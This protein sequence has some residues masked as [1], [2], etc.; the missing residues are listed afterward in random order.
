VRTRAFQLAILLL[1]L[2]VGAV[3]I[4]AGNYIRFGPEILFSPNAFWVQ[5]TGATV[6]ALLVPP[7]VYYLAELYDTRADFT[8]VRWLVRLAG[9]IVAAFLFLIALFYWFPSWK[10]WRAVLFYEALVYVPALV[11]VRVLVSALRNRRRP[12]NRALVVGLGSRAGKV[13]EFLRERPETG[14]QVLGC[15]S[16]GA[17]EGDSG[18]AA[19]E[20]VGTCADLTSLIQQRGVRLVIHTGFEPSDPC[21]APVLEAKLHGATVLE[22]IEMF[23]QIEQRIPVDHIDD[24]WLLV[25]NG[26][27]VLRR[28]MWQRV[29]RLVDIFG[30]ALLLL[31]F[32][33]IMLITTVAVMVSMGFPV[34]FRQ[35]RLGKGE[36]RFNILKFR[37]MK[38]DAEEST[39]PIWSA[40]ASDHRVTGLGR[41]LR[42]TRLDELPQLWNILVGEMSFIGPRPERPEFVEELKKEIPYYSIRFVVK[43]GLTGWAQ[44]KYRYGAS[45]EDAREKLCYDLFY[46]Q[47]S[48]PA[49][50]LKIILRTIQTVLFHSGS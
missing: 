50:N 38:R 48:S 30:A 4:T 1:D 18:A 9:A 44:V 15:L 29:Q 12:R 2:V 42:R 24:V 20:P 46:I 32:S 11:V 7:P 25:Q 6:F 31:L 43:P 41:F 40:G 17:E 16:R 23:R 45:V 33:P 47:E 14:I 5:F 21:I 22:D 35:V 8:R 19:L 27:N 28:P 13:V 34:I 39:G 3:A 37:T 49:L 36:R 10:M 26:F